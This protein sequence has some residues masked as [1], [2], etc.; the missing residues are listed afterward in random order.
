MSQ[1]STPLP[2]F[3]GLRAFHAAARRG[4]FK[5][6]AGD[7]GITESAVSHQVRR[8]EEFLGVALFDR[9]SGRMTL[10]VAG[11]R[12]FTSIDPAVGQI[13]EAT[14]ALLGPPD[15]KR[16]ALTVPSSLAAL[17]LIPNMGTFEEICPGIDLQLITTTRLCDLRRDQ[18]DLAL[19]H[20]HG[21][22]PGLESEFMFEQQGFPV[23]APGYFHA[24][25]D[26]DLKTALAGARLI[27][28]DLH[29]QEWT[30]WAMA[31]SLDPPSTRGALVLNDFSQVLE[32]AERGLG[33]AIGRRP[34]VDERC[35][36]GALVAPF[37]SASAP[38]AAAY[39]LCRPG[40][41]QPSAA[42]RKVQRWLT[43]LAEQQRASTTQL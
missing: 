3:A 40:D 14:A 19:R 29:P 10:T 13:R 20:G 37:G 31:H 28:N 9:S 33:L 22:W 39:Y 26:M 16:V 7:L 17:W 34:M 5:D 8:L 43:N 15:R 6:A 24:S 2:P 25:T 12:Y 32:A 36:K 38:S 23:C 42:A 21:D 18:I 35:A 4:R 1:G 11:E 30:E 41:A 27:V